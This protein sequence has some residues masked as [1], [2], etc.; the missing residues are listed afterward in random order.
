MRKVILASIGILA[1][2]ASATYAADLPMP[3]KGPVYVPSYNW[4]GFY[5]GLNGGYAWGSSDWTAGPIS[6]GSFNTN[7][8]VIGG[9]LGYNMQIGSFVWGL[10]GDLDWSTIKGSSNSVICFGCETKNTWLG[11]GRARIGYAFDRWLPYVTGGVAVGDV[12]AN[13]PAGSDTKTTVG[14]TV[15]GGLE[16]A[17]WSAWTWKIEYLYVSLGKGE[18]TAACG[19]PVPPVDVKFNANIVRAGLNYRF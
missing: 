13:T 19:N 11:T 7:G 2:S 6:T 3:T 5:V 4:T 8:A 10:E 12:Q 9:T 14:W 16:A 15:G 18:C 1:L 17:L